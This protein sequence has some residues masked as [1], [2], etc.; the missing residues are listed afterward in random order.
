[1]VKLGT[2][3]Q[4][5]METI[6]GNACHG[7]VIIGGTET[8]S[9]AFLPI[10]H[11]HANLMKDIREAINA[12]INAQPAT[13]PAWNSRGGQII[14]SSIVDATV[15]N[16]LSIIEEILKYSP[17]GPNMISRTHT[18]AGHHAGRRDNNPFIPRMP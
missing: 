16:V 17:K 14:A 15:K 4:H 10:E 5:E 6:A 8:R 11:K 18:M 2:Q 1:M 3:T 9:L 7:I 13:P 12:K